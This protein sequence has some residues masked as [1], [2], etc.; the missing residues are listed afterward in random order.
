MEV[1]SLAAPA[2]TTE[3]SDELSVAAAVESLSLTSR[4]SHECQPEMPPGVG[5]APDVQGTASD[6]VE[7]EGIPD[8]AEQEGQAQRSGVRNTADLNDSPDLLL[9]GEYNHPLFQPNHT[10]L[11]AARNFHCCTDFPAGLKLRAS[12]LFPGGTAVPA[13]KPRL[14]PTAPQ[15]TH[16]LVVAAFDASKGVTL[17]RG[18]LCKA[19][20]VGYLLADA[21]GI[22]ILKEEAMRIGENATKDAVAAKDGAQKLKNGVS[23][24]KAKLRK[25][26]AK[27]ATINL[28]AALEQLD[29]ELADDLRRHWRAPCKPAGL[30]DA[31]SKVVESRPRPKP[32]PA[33]A[34]AADICPRARRILDM[35]ESDEVATAVKA[36]FLVIFHTVRGSK[37]S[38]FNEQLEV[39]ELKYQHA[40]RRLKQA[41]AEEFCGWGLKS[42]EHMAAWAVRMGDMGHPIAAAQQAAKALGLK[43]RDQAVCMPGCACAGCV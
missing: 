1:P 3:S 12:E 14:P 30:P 24:K 38:F 43:R 13:A 36:A 17:Q 42:A 18:E 27:D 7:G 40:L 37:E 22:E 35:S 19:E 11:H 33:A 20:V 9:P 21:L 2:G 34:P 25:K 28:D 29:K 23:A 39:A 26:A 5:N 8:T 16:A 4:G 6:V 15:A 31:K 32:K 10:F 41:Y